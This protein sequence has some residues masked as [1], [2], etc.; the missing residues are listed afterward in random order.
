M[1]AEHERPRGV[2]VAAAFFAVGGF[3]E[4]ACAVYEAPRPLAFWP[5]WDALGR[6][7]LHFLLAAGLWRRLS[8]CRAIAMVYCL[9][10]IITYAIALL[11]AF[12]GAPVQYP[13]S[14][15]VQSLYQ[16]PSCVLLLPYLRSEDA[17]LVWSR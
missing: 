11:L 7:I 16:V 10:M 3:L 14:V 6:A 13:A 4:I 17:A 5:I 8:M 15:V 12:S 9:A 2:F 1:V